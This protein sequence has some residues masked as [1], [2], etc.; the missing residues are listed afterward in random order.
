MS[1]PKILVVGCGAVGLSQG[2][3]LSPH[4]DIT[5]LVRPGRSQAFSPPKK[6]Y[7]YKA[8][9]LRVFDDYRLIESPSEVSGEE[10]YCV[11][12]TLDG[13]TARSEAGTATLKGVGELIRQC[14]STFVV[15]D[16]V[17]VDIEEHYATTMGIS[18]ARLL[19]AI[20]MLAHQPTKII[21]IPPTADRNLIAQADLLYS[22]L[23][24]D[25]GLMVFNTQTELTKRLEDVY[26]NNG[27]LRLQRLPGFSGQYVLL[28]GML[29]LV[30]WN[31]DGYNEFSH[32]RNNSALWGLMLRAQKEILGLPRFGWAGWLLSWALG[33]WATAKMI[34]LPVEAALPL[35]CHE[36]NA[37]H[38][39]DKLVKQDVTVLDDL[40]AEGQR[41]GHKMVALSEICAKAQAREKTEA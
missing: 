11:F 12:D 41:Q 37:F 27:K 17:G 38:H 10:F 5:Y 36:F 39:G 1:K 29:Q 9:V 7:D 14:Q 40:V 15:Y 35:L 6:L 22:H 19:P 33:S 34:S 21:S 28:L 20:S 3:H 2:Y 16:A 26:N 24:N 8:N 25:I 4:A 30:A 13:H 18:K 31:L 23:P 32:F